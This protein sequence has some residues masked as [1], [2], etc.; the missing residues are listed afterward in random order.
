MNAIKTTVSNVP[1]FASDLMDW[2]ISVQQFYNWAS[3]V[4][5]YIDYDDCVVGAKFDVGPYAAV[6][7]IKSLPEDPDD[8]SILLLREDLSFYALCDLQQLP[9]LYPDVTNT[10]ED[11]LNGEQDEFNAELVEDLEVDLAVDPA[12]EAFLNILVGAKKP[13]AI[14]ADELEATDLFHH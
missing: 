10:V 1:L 12:E 5:H 9:Q 2:D 6:M 11:I 3:F 4:R 13:A 8:V 7:V 14:F